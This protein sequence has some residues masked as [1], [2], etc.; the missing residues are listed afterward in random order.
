[1]GHLSAA[2]LL[3]CHKFPEFCKEFPSKEL[4]ETILAYPM[5]NKEKLRTE[6]SVLYERNEFSVSG[7][8]NLHQLIV[9]NGLEHSLAEVNCL[10]K[11]I[12]TTPMTTSE[13]ERCFSTLKRIK[14]FLRSTMSEDRLSALG[15]LSA[16]KDVIEKK[17][18][19]M[20]RS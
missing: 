12:L 14:T 8:F 9:K 7:V 2:K 18:F 15:M 5:L 10:L 19:L 6:L 11:I 20:I 13:P 16:G 17:N 1:M 3:A 4:E